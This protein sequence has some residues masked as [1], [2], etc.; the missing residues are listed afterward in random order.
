VSSLSFVRKVYSGTRSPGSNVDR[1][2]GTTECSRRQI[3]SD[4]LFLIRN[5]GV[6][7]ITFVNLY[8]PNPSV[9]DSPTWVS[10]VFWPFVDM[11]RAVSA[12]GASKLTVCQDRL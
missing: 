3:G 4:K 1:P 12:V 8:L 7:V 2:C 9:Q 10:S 5:R 11:A 6:S